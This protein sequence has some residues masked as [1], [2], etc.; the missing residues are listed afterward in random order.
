LE[1]PNETSSKQSI[2]RNDSISKPWRRV[3]RISRSSSIQNTHLLSFKLN[4]HTDDR[5]SCSWNHQRHSPRDCKWKY[6]RFAGGSSNRLVH[7]LA[8]TD[9][10][11]EKRKKNYLVK[12]FQ[13]LQ[14]ILNKIK[15][16]GTSAMIWRSRDN[17][18]WSFL[19]DYHWL[20]LGIMYQLLILKR[21]FQIKA[22]SSITH[23][24]EYPIFQLT[25]WKL[26]S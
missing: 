2:L 16:F 12:L 26:F 15:V 6:S 23:A 4:L 14:K 3:S 11:L 17:N 19:W 20:T 13:K 9:Y 5:V 8:L 18:K 10:I 24:R 22:D 25:T 1:T 7:F 21:F